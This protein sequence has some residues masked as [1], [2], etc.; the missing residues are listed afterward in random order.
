MLQG[1]K[2]ENMKLYGCIIVLLTEEKDFV[3]YRVPKDIINKIIEMDMD[4][5]L[6]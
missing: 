1:S 5:Y 6:K 2:Y 3:E 4:F